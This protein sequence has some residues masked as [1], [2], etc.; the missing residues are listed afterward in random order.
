[1]TIGLKIRH[2]LTTFDNRQFSNVFSLG[3]LMKLKGTLSL[4]AHGAAVRL[5]FCF[6]F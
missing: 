1:M 4:F 6:V 2:T 5:R 3:I